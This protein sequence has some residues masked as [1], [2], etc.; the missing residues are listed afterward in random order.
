VLAGGL[1]PSYDFKDV[2]VTACV[3][4]LAKVRRP[5]NLAARLGAISKVTAST[6]PQAF[7]NVEGSRASASTSVSIKI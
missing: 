6:K 7:S 3:S 4:L 2:G 1:I 5:P